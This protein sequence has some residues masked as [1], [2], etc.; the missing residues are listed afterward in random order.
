MFQLLLFLFNLSL[1]LNTF[2]LVKPSAK[3][4]ISGYLLILTSHSSNSNSCD[5]CTAINNVTNYLTVLGF[6]VQMSELDKKD[7]MNGPRK[8]QGKRRLCGYQ[9]N[10]F[11]HLYLYMYFPSILFIYLFYPFLQSIT[12]KS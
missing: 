5:S 10:A 1:Y 11:C 8:L 2:S 4:F 9:R 3:T 12:L 6:T 7:H